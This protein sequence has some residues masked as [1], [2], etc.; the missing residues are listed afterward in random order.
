MAQRDIHIIALAIPCA[1]NILLQILRSGSTSLFRSVYTSPPQGS[2]PWLLILECPI[3]SLC[4]TSL[5]YFFHSIYF[6]L[7]LTFHCLLF[8]IFL[9]KS[10]IHVLKLIIFIKRVCFMRKEIFTI[11]VIAVSHCGAQHQ[12]TVVLH[13]CGRNKQSACRSCGILGLASLLLFFLPSLSDFVGPEHTN[14]WRRLSLLLCRLPKSP[15]EPYR[16]YVLSTERIEGYYVFMCDQAKKAIHWFTDFVPT[17]G[18][19]QEPERP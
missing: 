15:F 6:F 18:T 5:L 1:Q 17:L 4:S 16:K 19:R 14:K 12:H 10:Y 3:C 7:S 8:L 11:L 13:S 2:L 9:K